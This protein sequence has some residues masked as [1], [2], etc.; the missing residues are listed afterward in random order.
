[1]EKEYYGRLS[2]FIA[3]LY[4]TI[5]RDCLQKQLPPSQCQNA[6]DKI[7]TLRPVQLTVTRNVGIRGDYGECDMPLMYILVSCGCGSLPSP[8]AGWGKSPIT[9]TGI[10]DDIERMMSVYRKVVDSLQEEALSKYDYNNCIDITRN[11]C[12]RLDTINAI[13]V[14]KSIT[15]SY[16]EMFDSLQKQSMN[17]TEF[18]SYAKHIKELQQNE[19]KITNERENFFRLSRIVGDLYTTVYHDVLMVQLP[20]HTC[21]TPRNLGA[22]VNREERAVLNDVRNDNSYRKCDISLM[23]KLFRNACSSL[24]APTAG[25][26][27]PVPPLAIGVSDDIERIRQTRNKAFSH[28]SSTPV[29]EAEYKKY[30]QTATDVCSRMDSNH[31]AHVQKSIPGT[32]VQE[33]NKILTGILDT[34][35]Y[36]SYI[37]ALA[38]QAKREDD[39]LKIVT[40][41]GLET[42]KSISQAEGNVVK[43][44]TEEEQK[45]Q[46]SISQTEGKIVQTITDDGS[47]TRKQLKSLDDKMADYHMKTQKSKSQAKR[48]IVQTITDDGSD[49]RKQLKSLGIEVAEYRIKTQKSIS[50]AEGNIVHKITD[51]GSETR[52]EMKTLDEKLTGITTDHH[53]ETQ[54]SISQAE[55]NIVHKITD[56]GSETRKE[57]KVHDD[58]VAECHKKTQQSISQAEGRIVKTIIEEEQETRKELKTHDDKVAEYHTETQQ[59]I[60]SVVGNILRC[61]SL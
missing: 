38:A 60:S 4:P 5:C 8:S 21:P 35:M 40:E 54:Q 32:Y 14:H 36:R 2:R 57:L 55:G 27:K 24:P 3:D 49:T 59:S 10:A 28:I 37:D 46:N 58:K 12:I 11:I 47:E 34:E 30:V 50:Q 42:Q 53:M 18:N 61:V 45:I 6:A 22:N 26:D 23:Y 20:P 16:E 48:K 17:E 56:D 13:Y 44:I 9:G 19:D 25:W 51:D 33:L 1:M 39:I 43:T 41:T 15:T 29:S 52:K 7:R 31:A